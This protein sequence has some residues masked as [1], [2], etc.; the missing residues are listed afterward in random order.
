MKFLSG[1]LWKQEEEIEGRRTSLLLQQAGE[2]KNEV[3]L[4][5]ICES[6][7]EEIRDV[8]IESTEDVSYYFSGQL[9]QWFYK[10]GIYLYK[11]KDEQLRQKLAK[12]L[13]RIKQEWNCYEGK[14]GKKTVYSITGILVTSND[15]CLFYN[16]NIRAYLINQR[17]WKSHIRLLTSNTLEQEKMQFISGR[18]QE[19]LAILIGTDSFYSNLTEKQIADCFTVREVF[20][21][22]QVEN[23][24]LELYEES[25][26]QG[27][28]NNKS[29]I[30]FKTLK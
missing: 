2:K 9:L 1:Y 8:K 21:E 12:E 20:T 17:F 22:R 4:G 7:I 6:K 19:R 3:L 24:F 5:C 10:K 11:A 18:L 29:A 14:K 28:K 25:I 15:F 16:G 30:F 26:K 23:R 13:K 27:N